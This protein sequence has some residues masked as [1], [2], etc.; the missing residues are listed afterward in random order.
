[1]GGHVERMGQ[2]TTSFSLLVIKTEGKRP[3]EKQEVYLCIT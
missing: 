1:V 3:L 2:N